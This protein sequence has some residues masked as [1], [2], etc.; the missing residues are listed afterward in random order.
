MAILCLKIVAPILNKRRISVGKNES[1]KRITL[2]KFCEK[3]D[4]IRLINVQ[5]KLC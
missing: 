4:L 5:K 3:I 1:A 2:K